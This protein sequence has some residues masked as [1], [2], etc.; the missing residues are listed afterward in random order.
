M[1]A[2]YLFFGVTTQQ[3]QNGYKVASPSKL[4]ISIFYL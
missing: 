4:D 3:H 1:L 2:L